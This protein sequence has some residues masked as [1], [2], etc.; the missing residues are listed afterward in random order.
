[1]EDVKDLNRV[2]MEAGTRAVTLRLLGAAA[3]KATTGK[4]HS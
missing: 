2:A 4:S 1:M 3:N